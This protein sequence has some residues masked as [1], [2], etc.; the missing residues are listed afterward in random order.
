MATT[1]D[2]GQGVS[3]AT[4]QDAPDAEALAKNI[5]NGI[6]QRSVMRFDSALQRAATI[7]SPV[8]GM[9]SWLRDVN[10]VEV[11]DGL[12]WESL[13]PP[14]VQTLNSAFNLASNASNYTALNLGAVMSSNRAGMWASGQP[15]RLV[16][17]TAGTYAVG[18]VIVWP[19]TLGSADGR[20][21]FR[22]NGSSSPSSTAR[23]SIA[24]GSAGNAPAVASG[25]LV[26]TAAGQYAE[27]HANQNSGSTASLIVAVGMHRLS[28]AIA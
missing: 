7:T 27:V 5:A 15:T 17:P 2:F 23:F 1:D 16:A 11:Y 26:F 22:V 20:A 12:A 21:E 6:A 24:R 14:Q 28:T 18:G 13:E 19:G 3:I 9:V 4:L 25:Y 10:L 8:E